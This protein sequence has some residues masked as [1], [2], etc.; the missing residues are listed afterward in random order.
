MQKWEYL[1]KK[2][3]DDRDLNM[4]GIDGWELVSVVQSTSLINPATGKQESTITAYFKRPWAE[5]K[6]PAKLHTW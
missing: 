5:E 6:K 2:E 3:L 4:Y 1:I